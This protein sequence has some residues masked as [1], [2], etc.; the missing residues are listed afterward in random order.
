M[1]VPPRGLLVGLSMTRGPPSGLAGELK[2]EKN[3]YYEMCHKCLILLG[4]PN[5][6]QGIRTKNTNYTLLLVV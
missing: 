1:R 2:K 6:R 5:M 4:A 3:E